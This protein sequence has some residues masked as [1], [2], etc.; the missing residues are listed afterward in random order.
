MLPLQARV[1]DGNEGVL[2][3]PQSSSITGTSPSDCL[4][5]YAGHS[6]GVGVLT[7]GRDSVG[8]IDSLGLVTWPEL[9]NPFVS[10][11][12][13]GVYLSHSPGQ[14]QGC[15]YTICSYG[16]TSLSCTIRSG[17]PFPFS[18]AQTHEPFCASLLHLLIMWLIVSSSWP[19]NLRLQLWLTINFYFDI[20][21]PYGVVLT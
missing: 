1:D 9:G 14:I 11:N 16:Q 6:L 4:V 19:L 18:C 17:S 20:I 10:Q 8:V 13:S 15:A 3:I 5:S 2:C 21:D 12:P 7:F